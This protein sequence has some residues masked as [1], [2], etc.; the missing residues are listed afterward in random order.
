[1]HF[2]TVKSL[3]LNF[4]RWGLNFLPPPD[5]PTNYGCKVN[6]VRQLISACLSE[7]LDQF[8]MSESSVVSS[9][10]AAEKFQWCAESWCQIFSGCLKVQL[11]WNDEWGCGICVQ[12]KFAKLNLWWTGRLARATQPVHH[13]NG[14]WGHADQWQSRNQWL[15]LS[16]SPGVWNQN[17]HFHCIHQL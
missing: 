12:N 4:I 8:W 17:H 6:L 2:S 13:E 5:P 3:P 1:M 10:S 16:L 11:I 14:L 7:L 9:K 15:P